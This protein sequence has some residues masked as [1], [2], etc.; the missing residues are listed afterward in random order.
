MPDQ[1]YIDDDGGREF[2]EEDFIGETAFSSSL[3][4]LSNAIG[5]EKPRSDDDEEMTA[6]LVKWVLLAEWADAYGN[7]WL[8]RRWATGSGGA[9][10]TWDMKGML[11]E[12]LY[13]DRW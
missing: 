10:S 11:H 2:E 9:F 13:G 7:V 1:D 3:E 4:Y 6:I 8:T 5:S 12:A